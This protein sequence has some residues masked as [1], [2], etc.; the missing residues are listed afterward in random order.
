MILSLGTASEMTR[1]CH[2]WTGQ[3]YAERAPTGSNRGRRRTR[4]ACLWTGS[5]PGRPCRRVGRDTP[6]L[7]VNNRVDLW[8]TGCA[9]RPARVRFGR[10]RFAS[11]CPDVRLGR[12][13][14]V[15]GAS[16]SSLARPRCTA[17]GQ[18]C[19]L[20]TAP[21]IREGT[22][23]VD[24]STPEGNPLDPHSPRPLESTW[25]SV[26]AEL[27]PNQAAWLTSCKPISL[28]E[29]LAIVEVPDD[30]TRNQIEG[31][32]RG[33]LEDALSA[34]YGGEIRLVVT[35]N[36]EATAPTDV[37][38]STDRQDDMSTNPPLATV[39]PLAPTPFA[40]RP[41]R[42]VDELPDFPDTHGRPRAARPR[43]TRPGSTRSTPS[44]PSSSAPPT[45][46]RT[47]PR[48]RCPR[49]RARPT[50][51]CSSTATPGW[52]RPT[53]CTPSATTCAASTPAPGCATC[54]AR[55]SPTSSS[56]RSATTGRTGS[57]AATATSTCCSSTTSSS[58]RARPR[59]RRSSSTP[60]T[61]STTPTSRSC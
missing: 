61:R 29:G 19:I 40:R 6:W 23:L 51:R 34:V 39:L 43:R 44:R 37:V 56:T 58:W 4:R 28:H 33:Q 49:R 52:A 7:P 9:G 12:L 21:D 24:S 10:P 16:P 48:W 57:S 47:P 22:A 30:F 41:S 31:R 27:E 17:C 1:R 5:G 54:R 45:G 38:E 55:S 50:T 8:M 46:S 32:L 53:C 25:R 14:P 42:S 26:V 2:A 35:V 11:P 60:S 36:P 3:R 13:P 59:P 15:A 18:H 20:R